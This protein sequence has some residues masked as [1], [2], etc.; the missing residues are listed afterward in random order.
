[1]TD[2]GRQGPV[3]DPARWGVN[4][5]GTSV[6]YFPDRDEVWRPSGTLPQSSCGMAW[7]PTDPPIL[8][9]V[10]VCHSCRRFRRG[11]PP[12]VGV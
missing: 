12:E 8:V 6:H 7:S 1:M 11:V 3:N 2:G 5:Q 10:R 9:A 4:E